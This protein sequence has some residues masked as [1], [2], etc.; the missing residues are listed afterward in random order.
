MPLQL[1]ANFGRCFTHQVFHQDG[2][3]GLAIHFRI[4]GELLVKTAANEP[5]PVQPEKERKIV[6]LL[7]AAHSRRLS[8]C[9]LPRRFLAPASIEAVKIQ[10]RF[11]TSPCLRGRKESR[12]SRR[13]EILD[14]PLTQL[15]P[16]APAKDF[17]A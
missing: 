4:H 13:I 10:R 3:R 15:L 7:P 17:R 2:F 9:R 12:R 11:W 1:V 8:I 5:R 14:T 16:A 6:A